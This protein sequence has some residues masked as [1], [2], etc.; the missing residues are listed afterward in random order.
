MSKIDGLKRRVGAASRALKGDYVVVDEQNPKAFLPGKQASHKARKDLEKKKLALQKTNE[1]Q[2][3]NIVVREESKTIE[4]L[5]QAYCTGCGA[6]ANVCP[7]NAITMKEN[8]EGFLAPVIDFDKCIHCG[9][10]RKTCPPMNQVSNRSNS[11]TPECKAVWA[12]DE[13]RLKSSSGGMFTVL[14]E[15]VLDKGGY[16]CGAAYDKENNFYIK[17]KV[18]GDKSGLDE[19]RGSKY[20]QSDT[21]FVFRDI[22][23]YLEDGKDVLFC[24]TPCQVAGLKNFLKK[25]HEKLITCDLVC[26]GVPAYKVFDRYIK[27]KYGENTIKDFKFRQ[28]EISYECTKGIVEFKDGSRR[29]ISTADDE[30]EKLFHGSFMFRECC[31]DCQYAKLPRYGDFTVGDFWGISQFNP[32][33][34]DAKGT[35]LLLINNDKAKAII[36][37]VSDKF[38]LYED[39]PIDVAMRNNSFGSKRG[40]PAGRKRFYK[41]LEKDKYNFLKAADYTVKNKYDIGV[42]GLWF[43]ENYGSILT[44]YGLNYVLEHDLG[45]SVLMI[46]NPLGRAKG[47]PNTEPEKFGAKYY[48]ISDVMPV[49]ALGNLNKHCDTFMVGSDQLW[50]Y[51]LSK[52][53]GQTYFL[54]FAAENKKRIAYGTSFGSDH[55]NGPEMEKNISRE[56]LEKFDA[57]SV[58]EDSGITVCKNDF[59]LDVVKVCDPVF[60]CDTKVFEELADKN[61]IDFE[62]DG[63]VFAYIL[64]PSPAKRDVLRAAAKKFGK[65]VVVFLDEPMNIF[66]DNKN[67][68]ELGEEDTEIIIKETVPADVWLKY[69]KDSHFVVTDSFH[70]CC[71]ASLFK[72]PFTVM[73]NNKRGGGRFHSVLSMFALEDRIAKSPNEILKNTEKFFSDIDYKDYD[74]Y[75]LKTRKYSFD[76]LSNALF[77]PKKFDSYC[78]YPIMDSRLDNK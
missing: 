10:C 78:A 6:C 42:I 44:Y 17:H 54:G 53:Y 31:Y 48:N 43:G 32:E 71:F 35:T 58:R 8:E 46:N 27:E 45:L 60:L 19:L 39:A 21:G 9:L 1:I 64:D 76:W 61:S 70:G 62:K 7:K 34:N 37:Q 66:E 72:R 41:L 38:K 55:Y 2:L 16:V 74:K 73:R 15:Y 51:W 20:V 11:E 5:N 29:M 14:A 28:K 25:D 13:V 68:F 63:Y 77:S 40:K 30:F 12:D 24:G 3:P 52:N 47:F 57:I 59:G 33:F 67:K 56:N 18:I 22:K 4:A 65:K 23:K 49:S 50:N 36:E 75:L 26:H 69:L